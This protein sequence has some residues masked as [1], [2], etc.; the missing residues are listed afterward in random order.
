MIN[1]SL[2][3]VVMTNGINSK[4]AENKKFSDEIMNCFKPDYV[5]FDISTLFL[6]Y[7]TIVTSHTLLILIIYFSYDKVVI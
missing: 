4:M 2:G 1:Y 6:T 7:Y 5:G 3:K